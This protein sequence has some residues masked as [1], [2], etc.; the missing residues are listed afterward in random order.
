[1]S[2]QNVLIFMFSTSSFSFCI[3][4]GKILTSPTNTLQLP[5]FSLLT[6]SELTAGRFLRYC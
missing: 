4:D 6:G 2:Q 3:I 1:M 5:S